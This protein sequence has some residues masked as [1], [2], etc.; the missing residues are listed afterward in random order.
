MQRE[1]LKKK[2]N[3]QRRHGEEGIRMTRIFPIIACV[4]ARIYRGEMVRDDHTYEIVHH[5]YS[6][7]INVPD[8]DMV[9]VERFHTAIV[10]NRNPEPDTNRG[11]VVFRV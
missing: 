5:P 10:K 6:F 1:L 11:K 7:E 3:L 9:C 2:T 4:L 8:S